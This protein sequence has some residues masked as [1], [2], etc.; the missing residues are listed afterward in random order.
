MT[1]LQ[2]LLPLTPEGWSDEGTTG[3]APTNT[4]L[5]LIRLPTSLLWDP[6]VSPLTYSVV[7][8]VLGHMATRMSHPCEQRL[9]RAAHPRDTDSPEARSSCPRIGGAV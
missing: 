9:A 7:V 5:G 6:L 3:L 4:G 1:L 2:G 8:T